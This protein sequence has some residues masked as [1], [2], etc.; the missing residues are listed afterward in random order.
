MNCLWCGKAI[1]GRRDSKY[2]SRKCRQAGWRVRGY[3]SLLEPSPGSSALRFCYADPPYPGLAG[4]YYH[5]KEVDHRM[6]IKR[7]REYD[8]WALSTSARALRSLLPLCPPGGA[9]LRMGEAG[10]RAPGHAR[11]PQRLGAH[12]CAAGATD[13]SRQAGRALR[14]S[15]AIWGRSG[16]AQAAQVL[17]V[18]VRRHGNESGG[19]T[20]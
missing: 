16:G 9:R 17:R 13:D 15:C 10:R 2:C 6:L 8:G 7:L 12:H 3:S 19:R 4:R 1:A 20:G 5:C 11:P 18:A 14:S